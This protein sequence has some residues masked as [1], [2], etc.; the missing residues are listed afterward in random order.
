MPLIQSPQFRSFDDYLAVDPAE[1]PD[2]RVEYWDGELVAVMPESLG[3][4]TIATYILLMLVAAGIPFELIRHNCEVEVSGRPQSRIP[5][6]TI[7]DERHLVLLKKRA[8]ITRGMH[9]PQVVMEVVSPG[10][11]DSAN[12]KRDYEDKR[13]Q[14]ADRGI[15]EYWLIDPDRAWVMVGTLTPTGYTF[16]T[17]RNKT[18]IISSTFSTLA[19]TAEQI[20]Q[21]GL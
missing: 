16:T 5:D 3:N 13:D 6:L 8:T 19:L 1:L 10:D 4:G 21:A 18:V 15:P 9:P 20:L 17:F 2:G 7:I 11:Q 12:Y 14:Y